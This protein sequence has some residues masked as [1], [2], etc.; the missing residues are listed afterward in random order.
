M[1]VITA[2]K[3]YISKMTE[4]SGPGM[5]LLL[6]DKETTSI[7]SMVYS[8]SEILQ[9]EVYLFERIDSNRLDEGLK[10]LKCIVFL[11]PTNENIALLAKELRDPKYGS[12]YIYFCNIIPHASVKSLAESDDSESVREVKEFYA[13][14]L[15]CG[16]HLFSLN[17]PISL[18]GG[19]WIPSALERCTR[20][21]ISV[22]LSLWLRPMIRYRSGSE[23]AKRLAEK[24]YDIINKESSLFDFKSV[25]GAPP[26]LLL[27]L[28]RRDD[29]VTPLLNQWTYQAMV[30]ELLT[31]CNNRVDLSD[32][33]G[34]PKELK[35]VVLSAEHDKFYAKNLYSNYGEIGQT[36]KGLMEEFQAKA[37]SHQKVESIKDMKNFVENYPEFKKMSGTVSKHVTVVGELS[38]RVNEYLLLELSELEQDIVCRSDHS[39]QLQRVKK[40]LNNPKLRDSDALRIVLLYALR[41][42]KHTNNGTIGLLEMLS[43]RKDCNTSLVPA[44]LEW[45]G[46]HVRQGDLFG[47]DIRDARDA[48]RITKKIFK[49]LNG[50]DN[51]YTQHK[52]QLS[53]ILEEI[54]KGRP[55]DPQYPTVGNQQTYRPPQQVVVFI[56]GGVTYEESLA[57]HSI[58]S[59]LGN[60]VVIGGN[61]IHN[62]NSYLEEITSATKGIPFRHTKG[63]KQYLPNN[64]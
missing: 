5:K 42:E 11:R 6:M 45:S 48:V 20:G 53:E 2:V 10:H 19:S 30:H 24:T 32:V 55:L 58:N 37:K 13:D 49:G 1:N 12:Y 61:T 31:L 46:S 36:I 18:Q 38:N 29:P 57:V 22:L 35:Q 26:P 3:M 4:E 62:F 39:Q 34:V 8:K 60:R 25:D 21:I 41:Y 47:S 14:F 50:V 56:V 16:S 40:L 52:P 43:Q 17:L 23:L 59:Q 33:S 63:L 51:V 64:K 27:I 28:D 54:F 15:A 44:L 9:K 7:V